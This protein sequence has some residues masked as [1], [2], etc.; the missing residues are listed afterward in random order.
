MAIIAISQSNY[1]PWKGYFDLINDCDIF[2]FLDDV[3]YT[4]QDWRNRNLI[5]TKN[6]K[7]WLTI[8]VGK[9]ID[10]N[11]SEVSPLNYSWQQKHKKSI[12]M[13]YA[14]APFFKE[15]EFILN[16]I[17]DKKKWLSLSDLNQFSI[18]LIC[19]ALKINTLILDSKEIK[20]SDSKN[21]RLIDIIKHLNGKTYISGVSAQTYLNQSLFAQNNIDVIWKDYSNYPIYK[22]RFSPF[23]NYVSVLD[24]IFNT[25]ANAPYYIWGWRINSK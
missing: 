2:V 23:E 15:Y 5:K 16:E 21:K 14:N 9:K 25:G 22:Q 10:R 7:N 18:K 1:I 13:A 17:Y 8:P 12:Y 3:Q 24:L 20:K 11:I 4:K 6:G 19:K